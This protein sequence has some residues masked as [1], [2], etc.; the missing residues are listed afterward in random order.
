M[1]PHEAL[2]ASDNGF[3][4]RNKKELKEKREK[5][6]STKMTDILIFLNYRVS[7]RKLLYFILL[8]WVEICKLSLV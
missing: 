1:R 2:P 7:Q 6:K 3:I 8:W 4:I 5:K